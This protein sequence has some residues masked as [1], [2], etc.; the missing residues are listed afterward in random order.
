MYGLF[1]GAASFR[2]YISGWDVGAVTNMEN[3]FGGTCPLS[4]PARWCQPDFKGIVQKAKS[5]KQCTPC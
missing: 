2:Q 5:K 3:M 1:D 4:C